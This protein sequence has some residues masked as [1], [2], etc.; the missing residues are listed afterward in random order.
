MFLSLACATF[1]PMPTPTAPPP[2]L[3]PPLIPATPTPI[4]LA[5][6]SVLEMADALPLEFDTPFQ[7]H[8]GQRAVLASAGLTVELQTILRDWRCPNQME[9]SEAGAVNLAIYAWLTGLEPTRFELSTNPPIENFSAPYN[10]YEI[11]LLAVDPY[12]ETLDNPVPMEDYVVTFIV[13]MK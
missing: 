9:C 11:H 1:Q 12:P 7:L 13:S 3:E 4:P 8:V 10:A 6:S 5:T 2:V